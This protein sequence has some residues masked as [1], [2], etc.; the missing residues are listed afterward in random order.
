MYLKFF[1]LF[2]LRGNWHITLYYFQMYNITIWCLYTLRNDHDRRSASSPSIVIIFFLWWKLK[3][4]LLAMFQYTTQYCYCT[5]HAVHYIP[6]TCLFYNWMFAPFDPL[7]QFYSPFP[8]PVL[9]NHFSD[10]TFSSIENKY[11]FWK[12]PKVIPSDP[13][14]SQ[15]K[16]ENLQNHNLLEP[17][18]KWMSQASTTSMKSKG[19]R[20]PPWRRDGTRALFVHT[21]NQ[22]KRE[23]KASRQKSAGSNRT[24]CLK[25]HKGQ[26]WITLRW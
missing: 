20:V 10:N 6:M 25:N 22:A 5:H 24:K 7:C 14:Y 13:L 12:E 8:T 21:C 9:E 11:D 18:K 15:K 23:E 26:G 19:G 17:I 1:N 16:L 3:I 2:L 4:S